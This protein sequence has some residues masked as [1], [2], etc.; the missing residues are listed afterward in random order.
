RL[1]K[2]QRAPRNKNASTESAFPRLQRRK[3]H[4]SIF[5][6]R[7]RRRQGR[8]EAPQ[9]WH[10]QERRKRQDREKQETGDCDRTLGGSRERQEGSEQEIRLSY[11]PAAHR[12]SRMTASLLANTT[13]SPGPCV[14]TARASG[15]TY[16]TVPRE[17]SASSSP[18]ILKICSRPSS[19]R[20][21]TVIP[22]DALLL[23]SEG[24]TISALA[25][26]ARQ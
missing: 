15:D 17:G 2:G 24:L 11:G 7:V 4:G 26:R 9:G 10:A 8:H 16:D 22:K 25:R 13:V 5:Q 3:H 12:T 23:S 14:S 6:V 21:V 19:L 1:A 20:R 18:T